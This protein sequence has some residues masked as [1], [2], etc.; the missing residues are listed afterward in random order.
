M[1]AY[2]DLNALREAL[3]G[4]PDEERE[5]AMRYYQ[6]YFL[7]AGAE[8][9]QK[10]IDELGSPADVAA[11]ILNDYREVVPGTTPRKKKEKTPRRGWP[12]WLVVLIGVCA[13]IGAPIV[14]AVGVGGIALI[15][16]LVIGAI[17]LLFGGAV[18]LAVLPLALLAGGVVLCVF[19][20]F[21]VGK[22]L[23]SAVATL[24][25]GLV[26]LAVGGLLALLVIKIITGCSTPVFHLIGAV[27]NWFIDLVH[28]LCRKI[29][30][31]F[32]R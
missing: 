5:N 19:A 26:V 11:A 24:G 23:A 3:A 6:D 10:V 17:A 13:V 9:E 15:L 12:V 32:R 30:E 14:G 1:T 29:R 25:L 20:V 21:A 8:N 22:G 18:A 2:E 31:V 16:G 27:M 7:D 28:S 4:L